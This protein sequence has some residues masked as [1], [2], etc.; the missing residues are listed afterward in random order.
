MQ[1]CIFP[2]RKIFPESLQ[3]FT[4][5][6][7]QENAQKFQIALALPEYFA[8]KTSRFAETFKQPI[9]YCNGT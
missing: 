3:S 8:A 7:P 6:K 9:N 2:K 4:S 5:D 1:V